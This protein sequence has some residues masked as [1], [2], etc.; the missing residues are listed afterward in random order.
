MKLPKS[1]RRL[2]RSSLFRSDV[3]RDLDDE[4]DFHFEQAV[5]DLMSKGMSTSDALEAARRRFGDLRAYRHTLERID[6][7][8]VRMRERSER[9][10]LIMRTV[11]SAF[12]GVRRAPGF[13]AAVVSILALGIGAN[14][15]MFGVVDRL[16][17]SP[18][19]HVEDWQ[20]VRHI[21]L[22]RA[23]SNGNVST[24]RYLTHPDYEDFQ[25]VS[26]WSSVAAYAGEE[27]LTLGRGE[28]AVRVDVTLASAS[29]FPLLGVQ[30]SLGR[31]FTEEEDTPGADPTVV[32][33]RE[34]WQRHFAGDLDILGRVLD[35]G[36]GSYT[37][38]GIAPAGFTG[39]ELGPVDVWLP[40]ETAQAINQDGTEWAEHRNWWWLHTVARLADGATDEA[41]TAQATA[42]HGGG[43]QELIAEGRYDTNAEILAAPIIAARGPDPS[44]EAS[45][46]R[47][48]AGVSVI[49]LLIACL[50]VAN[51][52]LARG[53]RTRR[54]IAVR[55]ALGVSRKRLFAQLLTESLVLAGLGSAAALAIAVVSAGPLHQALL[56]N[57]A[58]TDAGLGG[59]LLLFTGIATVFAAV[60]AG[61]IPALQVSRPDVADCLRSGGRGVGA[62]RSR[63]RVALLVGQA[64]LSVV[65]LVGAGLFVRSLFEARQLDLGYDS[66]RVAIVALEWN[67]S[68]PG[69]ERQE[70]YKRALIALRRLPGVRSAGL[71][72][73]V[74]FYSSIGIG[75]PGVPGRDSVPRH[76]SGGPYVNK[77]GSG[78]FEAMGLAIVRGRSF[79]PA[80]DAENSP[81]VTIVSESMAAAYWPEADALG[82]CLLVGI[83]E[84]ED[85]PCSE[86]VGVVENH[87][88]QELVEDDHHLYF[89]NQW[90]PSF[91]GPPQAIMVGTSGPPEEYIPSL[92]AEASDVS[93]LIRFA[94]VHPLQRF[95][96]P[97]LRSWRLGALMFTLFGILA[98]IV[99]GCGLYSVL[100]FDVA[101]RQHELGV[102]SA[103]GASVSRI[104]HLVMQRA[105]LLVVVGVAI[106]LVAAFSAAP[107]VEPLLFGVSPSD[108]STYAAVAVALLAVA[109][110][111]GSLPAWRASRVDPREALQAD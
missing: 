39:A 44:G 42:L 58:F 51:L 95:I 53:I 67:E 61:A 21:Y 16:L 45:V 65:L 11:G 105:L 77:V 49:V 30:P 87:R 1:I 103:L 27:P 23:Q 69:A 89:V 25:G 81:P 110:F 13:A 97:Q 10:D 75:K 29:L 6:M 93:A 71:T 8:R 79:E 74:P 72:Y 111:A 106:G 73:T 43:R 32:L 54:E 70:V 88:R 34:F 92:R 102:R 40:L 68:L 64:A 19:Q 48:L 100:A 18:P 31:F 15:V 76:A 83:A 7:G 52:L 46:A 2:F 56:P 17:L 84:D 107:F 47:W 98:L 99:A 4:L 36:E 66:E 37:V 5:A 94:N 91:S 108:P 63:T 3:E 104:V 80:D 85:V 90:H 22:Q 50:N 12:R 38:V 33:A 59:R 82:Q 78:Y 24:S 55:L 62:S 35:I 96:D 101:L 57:V 14:A 28:A 109:V 20:S 41:A 9:F 60:L 26:G 86:V